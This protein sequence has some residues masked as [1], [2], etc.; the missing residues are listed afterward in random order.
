[1]KSAEPRSP[2]GHLRRIEAVDCESGLPPVADEMLRHGE[3]QKVP[4]SDI[5][6]WLGRLWLRT[7][8]NETCGDQYSTR[9]R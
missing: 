9:T 7:W 1:M 4:R 3:R 5:D 6:C 2:P 8:Q